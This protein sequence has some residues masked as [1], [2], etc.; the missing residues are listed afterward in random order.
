MYHL[1]NL[2][3]EATALC[4]FM[5]KQIRWEKLFFIFSLTLVVSE[6]LV[7][8]LTTVFCFT[9][10]KFEELYFTILKFEEDIHTAKC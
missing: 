8:K 3:P 2:L 4:Y 1:W 7:C 10:L 9:I 6:N 5:L